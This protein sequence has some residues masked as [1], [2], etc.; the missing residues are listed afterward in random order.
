MKT[1]LSVNNVNLTNGG[2][3]ANLSNREDGDSLWITGLKYAINIRPAVDVWMN[4][5]AVYTAQITW[6][7][8]IH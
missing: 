5:L 3:R 1:G 7:M 8:D 4:L 6:S 2:W